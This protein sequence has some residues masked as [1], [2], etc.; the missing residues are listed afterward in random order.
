MSKCWD[1]TLGAKE[2]TSPQL[3]RPDLNIQTTFDPEK[4]QNSVT[5]LDAR[6]E[7]LCTLEVLKRITET[8]KIAEMIGKST[9]NN[10]FNKEIK[11]RDV[12]SWY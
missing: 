8:I 1:G 4:K 6:A 12:K 10:D 11:K 3:Y 2:P 7:V 9:G 5:F